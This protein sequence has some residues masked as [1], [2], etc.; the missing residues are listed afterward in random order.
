MGKLLK[1]PA[2][3]ISR[4]KEG[5]TGSIILLGQTYTAV[6]K[7][8]KFTRRMTFLGA[9]EERGKKQMPS[10]ASCFHRRKVK[11]NA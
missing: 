9:A 10:A 1:G 5:G 11:Q 2:T 3:I 7:M 8:R 4:K 6:I